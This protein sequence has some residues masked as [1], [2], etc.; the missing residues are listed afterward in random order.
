MVFHYLIQEGY[1]VLAGFIL[2]HIIDSLL[3][4]SLIK[5]FVKSPPIFPPFK[6]WTWDKPPENY[7]STFYVDVSFG[8]LFFF[9]AM[10]AMSAPGYAIMLGYLS[11]I[12]WIVALRLFFRVR[13][14]KCQKMN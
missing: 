2:L 4:Y 12:C 1:L 8:L 10:F 3:G 6:K 13:Q 5:L 9:M 14:L 11:L 7:R